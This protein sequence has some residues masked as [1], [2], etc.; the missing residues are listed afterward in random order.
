MFG[1]ANKSVN[2]TVG[3]ASI[4]VS[5]YFAQ[6]ANLEKIAR[7]IHIQYHIPLFPNVFEENTELLI[8]ITLFPGYVMIAN[9][10]DIR[11]LRQKQDRLPVPAKR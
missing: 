7:A 3:E 6:A 9:T 10:I 2:L 8:W 11:L 1:H 5:S 4:D